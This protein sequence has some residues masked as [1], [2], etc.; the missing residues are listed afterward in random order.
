MSGRPF[1]LIA[2]TID[3]A[4]E[5]GLA[6]FYAALAGSPVERVGPAGSTVSVRFGG[7]RL[8]FRQVDR[9]RAPTWPSDDMPMQMHLEVEV[10]DLGLACARLLELGATLPS[11]QPHRDDGLLVMLDPAGHPFCI[12]SRL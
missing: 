1:S 5:Q 3:G 2:L 8:V 11:Y 9:Y 6:D 12:A 4:D 7:L 10:D